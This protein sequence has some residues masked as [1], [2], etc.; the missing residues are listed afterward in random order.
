MPTA[1]GVNLGPFL[2]TDGNSARDLLHASF[3]GVTTVGLP[4]SNREGAALM[5][6]LG[7]E[8]RPSSIRMFLGPRP[9]QNAACIYGIANGATG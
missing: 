2:A 7:F 4:A 5:R 1:D 9:V 3:G 6:D 8:P